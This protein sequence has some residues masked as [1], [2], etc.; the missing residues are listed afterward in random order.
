M[1]HQSARGRAR[2]G[3]I[4]R[5]EQRANIAGARYA[6]FAIRDDPISL[7]PDCR[8]GLPSG[9][10]TGSTLRTLF[11]IL[12]SYTDVSE[13]SVVKLE[14]GKYVFLLLPAPGGL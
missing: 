10:Y 1:A 13:R 3:P 12:S 4:H 7:T 5:A 11:D 9:T 8:S 6:V 14:T 2:S